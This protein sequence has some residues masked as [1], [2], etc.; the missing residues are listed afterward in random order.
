[1]R[2]LSLLPWVRTA[3]G[4]IFLLRTTPIL[5][6]IG[7]GFARE[8]TPLLGW[9][10]HGWHVAAFGASLPPSVVAVLCIVRTLAAI[11]FV[12]GL[13][14]RVSGLVAGVCGYAVLAQDALAFVNSLHL[15]YLGT[16]VLA[17]AESTSGVRLVRAVVASIYGWSAIAKLNASWLSGEALRVFH[18][19]GALRGP[20][21][22]AIVAGERR[23]LIAWAIVALELTLG[24]ALLW[25]RTRAVA[26]VVAVAFHVGI[27]IAM[28]PDVLGWE[29]L[30]LLLTFWRR[31]VAVDRV[32]G[33]PPMSRPPARR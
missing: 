20:L 27:E 24:P 19:E 22:D 32:T 15:L 2:S 6:P 1:M 8:A 11:A 31:R 9:P 12:V 18:E 29:M 14:P 3:F 21:G 23:A 28:R 5:A 4:V 30:V 13:R 26:L 17:I 7:V 25:R 33:S 16:M 10:P